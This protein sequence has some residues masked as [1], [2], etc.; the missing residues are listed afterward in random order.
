MTSCMDMDIPPTNMLTEDSAFNSSTGVTAYMANLYTKIP[1]HDK[2]YSVNNRYDNSYIVQAFSCIT[3]EAIGRDQ[4]N[5]VI[6]QYWDG[7][8]SAVRAA[9]LLIESLPKYAQYHSESDLNHWLGEA[10]FVRGMIYMTFA[11]RY[12]GISLV[13]RVLNYPQEDIESFMI[14]RSSEEDTWKQVESDFQFAIDNCYATSSK[15]RVNKYTAA[16]YKASAMLH[17]A[18]IANFNEVEHYDTERDI[19]LCGI[20]KDKA[21]YFYKSAYEATKIFDG[22]PYS[23]YRG[24]WKDGDKD[25]QFNNFVNI[26]QKPENCETIFMRSYGY[27]EKTHSWDALYGPLQLRTSGL[28]GGVHPT[29]EF[30]ELF[31][32]IDKDEN[33]Y[34][35]VLNDDGTHIMYDNV[36]DIYQDAEPRLRATVILPNDEFKGE[37]ITMYR[38][39][40]TPEIPSTDF[41]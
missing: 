22:G 26:H 19:R 12:G 37:K 7:A 3:G 1:L 31:D 5:Q 24:D 35:K 8:Y 9:N 6:D 14:H 25:A 32:G 36:D 15:N 33:G 28:S 18:S 20:D 40:Y 34:L 10:H 41:P 39:I 21:A 38:G 23:L 30:V 29:L 27:P 16:A 4:S 2:R 13:T 11:Q 17:A